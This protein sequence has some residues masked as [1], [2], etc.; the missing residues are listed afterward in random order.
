VKKL[1]VGGGLH[2]AKVAAVGAAMGA[3][4][5]AAWTATRATKA[6]KMSFLFIL[7]SSEGS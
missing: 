6:K 4:A 5:V 3:G 1:E 7:I 2:K